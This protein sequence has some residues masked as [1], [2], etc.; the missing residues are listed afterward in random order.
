MFCSRGVII[1]FLSIITIYMQ[2]DQL[3]SV[4]S[5]GGSQYTTRSHTTRVQNKEVTYF[6]VIYL[7][8]EKTSYV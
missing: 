5:Y 2:Y 4:C 8:S 3:K 1:A 6:H 7:L